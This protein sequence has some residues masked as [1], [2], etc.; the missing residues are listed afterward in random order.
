MPRRAIVSTL[1]ALC[2]SCGGQSPQQ[3]QLKAA[4]TADI[5]RAPHAAGV[6]FRFS[7]SDG[8]DVRLYRLPEMDEVAWTF[9]T[10][11]L[12]AARVVGFA[13]DGDAIYVWSPDSALNVLDLN[14]GRAR[15]VD[16][17]IVTA[18][19]GPFGG[20]LLL[21]EGGV[22]ARLVGRQVTPLAD[23]LPGT[24]IDLWGATRGNLVV[25][26]DETGDRALL[27]IGGGQVMDRYP[28]PDG[29]LAVSPWGDAAVVGTDSGVVALDLVRDRP[30]RFLSL[31]PP[32]AITFSAAAH[33]IYV[34]TTTGELITIER[35]ALD[36]IARRALP[37]LV[38][39][40]RPDPLGRLLLARAPETGRVL[41]LGLGRDSSVRSVE[42]SWDDDLPRVAPDGTL[43]LR[44]ND[45]VVALSSD[46]LAE[47]GRVEDGAADRWLV[48]PWDP[49]RPVLQA[50]REAR[51]QA[52][53][54][55]TQLY[56]Q[57]SSTSNPDW[58][59]SLARDL[60]LAGM[61]VTV[62]PPVENDV[63]YRVVLGP[64]AT[65]DEAEQI[66]RTLG[67]PYWIFSDQDASDQ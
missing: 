39:Q 17:A 37:G 11:D 9:D 7:G 29:P 58:A 57:I 61:K 43:L 62:L 65:R 25:L 18:A 16:S 44:R 22:V 52:H 30:N 36:E 13:S 42:G 48:A 21:R 33:R 41:V 23:D 8:A 24:A 46:D 51:A 20:L 35:F 2:T 26:V 56:V 14:S 1:L 31:D 53:S 66:G 59:A 38:R 12:V 27:V 5:D 4:V 64:Y 54:T 32:T 47:S 67:M 40:L 63:M 10:P 60:R 15:T 45:A 34:A 50:S 3:T 28:I 55:D 19:L 6:A 49:R